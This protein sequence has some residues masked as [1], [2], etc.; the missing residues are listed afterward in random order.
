MQT[1]N[2][3]LNIP[4]PDEFVVITKVELEK[5]EKQNLLGRYWSMKDLEI[6]INKKHEWIK[7]NILYPDRFRK[8]LDI[9]N[10]GFVYYP[11]SRGQTWSFHALKMVEF[12]DKN[13]SSIFS[14][15]P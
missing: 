14:N 11:K 4:I 10:G 2:V 3:T 6:H 5:L 9:E 1:L 15:N 13:F 12:L 7:D 8:I